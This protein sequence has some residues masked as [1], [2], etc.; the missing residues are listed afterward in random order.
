MSFSLAADDA[1]SGA[2]GTTWAVD[3]GEPHSGTDVTV[4]GDGE[5]TV[6]YFSTDVAGN[7]E[8]AHGV[9]VRIDAGAPET[10]D[11]APAGWRNAETT[12]TLTPADPL[13]GVT[14]GLAATTWE[15]DGGATETGTSVLV[16]AP[17][18]HSGDGARAITYRSTDAVG[19]RETDRTATVLVDTLAPTTRDDLAA[20]PPVHTDPVTVT[21][22]ASDD[23]GSLDVSGIAATHHRVD[24]GPWQ[25][26][27]SVE[28]TGDGEHTVSYFSTDNAGNDEAVRTSATLTIAA[29]PPGASSDDAPAGWVNHAVT[30]T[31]TPGA[32]ALR[33]TW[34]LD[35][36]A[37]QTGTTVAVAAPADHSTDGVHLVTYR[38]WAL[39]D[40]AEP[41]RAATVR[42]DTTA[43]QTG[44]DAPAG[45]HSGAVTL[46][47]S[48]ADAMSGVA[49]TVWTLDGGAAQHGTSVPVSG[50]GAHTITYSSTD[51]AGN[52]ET[53]RTVTVRIDGTAPQASCAEAGRWFKTASATVTIAASDSGSG[54]SKVEYRLGQGAWQTGS[55]AVVTGAGA[56]PLSYRVT[57][58][59]GNVTTGQCVVGIDK[60]RP[61]AVK[62]LKSKGKKNGKLKLAFKISD[63]RPG[64]GAAKVSKIVVTTA[65]GKRVATIKRI[66]TIVKTNAKVKLVVKKK[67]KKGS[68][69]FKVY[70]VDIAGNK[71]KNSIPAKLVIR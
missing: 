70:V 64:C 29:T 22:S 15:L 52:A 63:P 62:A 44:A 18:D 59:C 30:V 47:L 50:D 1:T 9:T 17:S 23:N 35:G 38:S 3:G 54:V 68:Y 58:V 19:N 53:T 65:R 24:D 42:I 41:T 6:T 11:D 39:G 12:V 4:T 16:A 21:L 66:K 60:A 32:R 46:T 56:H 5:H 20:G 28:V 69:R 67:L 45:W 40:V 31:L 33:T 48:P 10:T 57:D 7:A 34:E 49:G 27:T 36:G 43:P 71:S 8:G 51:N 13:S 2:D 14:S 37:S 25:T 26:G 61:K 55:S